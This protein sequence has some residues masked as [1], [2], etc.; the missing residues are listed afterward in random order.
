MTDAPNIVLIVLDTMR[1]DVLSA[2]GGAAKTPNLDSLADDGLV[3]PS[4][5]APSP[6]TVP[7]HASLFTGKYPSQHGVHESREV[8]IPRTFDLMANATGE[9]ITS[10]L[11]QRGYNAVGYS[12][13][14]SIAPGS[15]FDDAFNAFAL[16]D[17]T[18]GSEREAEAIAWAS[19]YGKT[20][21][22]VTRNLLRRGRISDLWRLY[23]MSKEIERREK[24]RD[25]PRMKGGDALAALLSDTSFEQPFFLFVN[26]FEMH[27]PY[28]K[29]EPT[30]M[31]DL[32]GKKT[33]GAAMLEE[34]RKRYAQEAVLVD[35]FLGSVVSY[36]KRCGI[37]DESLVVVTSDHGQELKEHG[38]Y[39]HG[40]FLHREIVEVPLIVKYPGNRKEASA[41]GHQTL[42][43]I[44]E[45]VKD[46]L[47]GVV[48]GRSLSA[49]SVF[50]ES[51][52][53]PHGLE[54]V[55]RLAG[56]QSR[57]EAIDRPRKAVYREG[58]R[59]VVDGA[60]GSI[61]EFDFGGK[62]AKAPDHKE[63]V[64]EM[65]EELRSLAGPGFSVPAPI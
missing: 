45:M 33:I 57:R 27:E 17:A 41:P 24:L 3:Y 34:I 35:S 47:A 40:T 6:W 2:Y 43:G 54:G 56:F 44:P 12:A 25:Y 9:T 10:Y 48:D 61:E 5:V 62:Q 37:Y 49:Q 30:P 23:R 4:C 51:F 14:P 22:E 15:G 36:L 29:D 39:G 53:I 26:L 32:F 50:S 16:V 11:E 59:L 1:K 58:Y 31:M 60:A 21:Q 8:K 63:A 28:V 42:I 52:G 64:N 7:S 55:E 20:K 19:K 38:F 13:N 18:K 46:S 65:L